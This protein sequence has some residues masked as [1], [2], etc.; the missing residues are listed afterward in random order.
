MSCSYT[1]DQIAA[2]IK[3]NYWREFGIIGKDVKF[4]KIISSDIFVHNIIFNLFIEPIFLSV[5]KKNI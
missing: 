4:F 2:D 5:V 3:M 1:T